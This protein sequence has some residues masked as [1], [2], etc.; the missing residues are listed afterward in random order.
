MTSIHPETPSVSRT[1]LRCVGILY[2]TVR[3]EVGADS[4]KTVELCNIEPSI[5]K[6]WESGFTVGNY[7]NLL[8]V[9]EFLILFRYWLTSLGLC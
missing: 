6:A 9:Q 4:P 3:R 8:C 2:V 7:K 1:S 5:T